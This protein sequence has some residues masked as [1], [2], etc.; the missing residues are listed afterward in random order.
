MKF[1][2]PIFYNTENDEVV[3]FKNKPI[4]IDEN[5]PYINN[6]LAY[7]FWSWLIYKFLAAPYAYIWFKIFKNVKFHNSKILKK[8]K[9]GGYFIYGN[10]TNQ[11]C[12]GICPALICFPKKP[13]IIV[14]SANV[15]MKFFGKFAKMCGALPIPNS[16]NATKNFNKAIE[17]SL[18]K[19]NPIVIYPEAHLWPY[20]TKIRNFSN[21][22][23]RYPV[24]YNKPVFTF[25]TVYKKKKH[26]KKPKVEIYVD[27]PFYHNKNLPEKIAQ[28]ELRNDVYTKLNERA[29][30]SN[31]EYVKYIKRSEND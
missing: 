6:S 2:K 25:T 29:N 19:N 12:D 16:I 7:K 28:A 17:L 21:V 15:S 9:K 1:D 13:G 11:F 24:K 22:S 3:E 8:H 4:R 14:N 30:L 18:E 20:Y 23:F 27:G 10:H 26:S 31:Y 5:Y